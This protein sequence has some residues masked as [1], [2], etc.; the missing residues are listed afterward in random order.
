M[1]KVVWLSRHEMTEEQ[2]LSL[3]N[4]I[5]EHTTTTENLLWKASEE[6]IEDAVANKAKWCKLA[7]EYDVIC[8]VFPPVA[9]EALMLINLGRTLVLTPVSAQVKE[10][11]KEGVQIA[12]KHL[13]WVVLNQ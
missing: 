6:F 8:G 5:G 2:K 9:I 7:A 11:R 4:E 13:R 3:E 1:K 10:E 12:F